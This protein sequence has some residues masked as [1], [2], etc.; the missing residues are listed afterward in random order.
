MTN[1]H[2]YAALVLFEQINCIAWFFVVIY[3]HWPRYSFSGTWFMLG[4][5]KKR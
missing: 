5:G 1:I 4:N 2:I 3:S